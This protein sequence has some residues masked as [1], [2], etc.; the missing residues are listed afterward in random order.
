[1]V[2]LGINMATLVSGMLVY[3]LIIGVAGQDAAT[4]QPV[5]D[6][7]GKM[8]ADSN[9]SYVALCLIVKNQ[10]LDVLEWIEWHRCVFVFR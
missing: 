1:M 3:L 9:S 4:Q 2:T 6:L 10:Y 5:Y 7:N 8:I